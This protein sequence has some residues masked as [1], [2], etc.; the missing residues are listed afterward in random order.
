MVCGT[1]AKSYC[2]V[3]NSVWHWLCNHTP[4]LFGLTQPSR[5]PLKS[6][7]LLDK[8]LHTFDSDIS[9][10]EKTI[11]FLTHFQCRH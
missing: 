8:V 11:L 10:I 2:K 6:D 5:L 7:V 3:M 1:P 4:L 9:V